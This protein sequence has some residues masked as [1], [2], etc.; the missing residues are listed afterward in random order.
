MVQQQKREGGERLRCQQLLGL[1]RFPGAEWLA[2]NG[3]QDRIRLPIQKK[4]RL[5]AAVSVSSGVTLC[6]P[7]VVS[8]VAVREFGAAQKGTWEAVAGGFLSSMPAWSIE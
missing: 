4:I 5:Y 2:L 1:Q 7:P 8:T 6:H 3:G